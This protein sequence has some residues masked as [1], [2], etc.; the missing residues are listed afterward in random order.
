MIKHEA[1]AYLNSGLILVEVCKSRRPNMS[2]AEIHRTTLPPTGHSAQPCPDK[3][4][5]H[6][7]G[8]VSGP[9]TSMSDRF[10]SFA[11]PAPQTECGSSVASSRSREWS[12]YQIAPLGRGM[13]L[14]ASPMKPDLRDGSV[15]VHESPELQHVMNIA[16]LNRPR[17]LKMLIRCERR[18]NLYN[19]APPPHMHLF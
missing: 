7:Y 17:L 6:P 9:A 15:N 13:E 14:T 12:D 2:R 1:L 11:E 18:R 10:Y 8:H 16:D 3:G 4:S 5:S 19:N